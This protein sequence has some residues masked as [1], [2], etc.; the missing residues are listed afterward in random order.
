MSTDKKAMNNLDKNIALGHKFENSVIDSLTMAFH[1]K[2]EHNIKRY[3]G[4]QTDIENGTDMTYNRINVDIT[5]NFKNKTN[6]PFIIPTRI[7]ATN[8]HYFSL[9]IRTGNNHNGYTEFNDIVIVLGINMH[10]NQYNKH[11]DEIYGNI[12]Y[13]AEDI[14]T[15]ISDA[16]EIYNCMI[17]YSADKNSLSDTELKNISKLQI[18]PNTHKYR[19]IG[20][21]VRKLI[22]LAKENNFKT[23]DI[24]EY[25][26]SRR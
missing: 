17:D 15:A 20:P 9:G 22:N 1:N 10:N 16:Y 13:Y 14:A 5:A 18:N 12:A 21:N 7:K 3:T 25:S 6:M 24:E 19:K 26:A 4:T 8:E 23:A 11:T 2:N